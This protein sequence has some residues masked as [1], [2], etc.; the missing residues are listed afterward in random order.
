MSS[1]ERSGL[2]VVKHA[3]YNAEAPLDALGELCTPTAQF[4]VRSNYAVPALDTATWRLPVEGAVTTPLHLTWA[5]LQ[6]LPA[7]TITATLEC[8]G[9]GRTGFLPLPKGEPWTLGAVSTAGW[10][11]VSLRTVLDA[12]GLRSSVIEVLVEGADRGLVEGTTGD[13]P[14][15]RSLPSAKALDPDTLLVYEMNGAPLPAAHGGP[16]RLVVPDWYGIASVKWVA[17]LVALEEPFTGYYQAQRYVY[18][19]PPAPDKI[20]VQMMQVRALITRP[21]TGA[22]LSR[23]GGKIHG[24]AW[25]GAA[26]IR[27]VEVSLAGDA[28]W[29]PARLV[30]SP[31]PHTWQPWEFDLPDLRPGRYV[32]RARAGDAAGNIQPD[33]ARWNRLGYANNSIHPVI[34]DVAE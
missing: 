28:P 11:G 14:F 12:A 21:E 23:T 20:P 6:A 34:V 13:L 25:S 16:L 2:V 18:E 8:A 26:P 32:F 17:R 19:Y 24:M 30:G 1:E 10:R 9:N 15:A 27:T 31:P 5:D 33:Q 7:R 3:P 4:Y 22:T 29:Q